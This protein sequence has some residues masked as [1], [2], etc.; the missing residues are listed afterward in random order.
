MDFKLFR[1]TLNKI[2]RIQFDY[3]NVESTMKR[4]NSI[5]AEKQK[6]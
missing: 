6:K 1:N 5:L 2:E 3:K 4:N